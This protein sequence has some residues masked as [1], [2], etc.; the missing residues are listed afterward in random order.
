MESRDF[1][2][3]RDSWVNSYRNAAFS[4]ENTDAI[5]FKYHR[6]LALQLLASSQVLVA[7][8]EEDPDIVYGWIC[9]EPDQETLHYI[10]VKHP[11]RRQGIA[12]S[13][14]KASGFGP[15]GELVFSHRTRSSDRRL[16]RY[17]KVYNLYR[18]FLREA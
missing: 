13:L 10:Y 15:T 3:V 17:R 1:A 11:F 7:C 8:S 12:K 14:L 9:V 6:H 2:L 18:A 16:Q 5:Y 4:R